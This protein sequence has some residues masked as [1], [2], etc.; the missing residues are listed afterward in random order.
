[1]V[2][3]V[4]KRTLEACSIKEGFTGQWLRDRVPDM[5]DGALAEFF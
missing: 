2:K 1:M 3:M 4:S 5:E